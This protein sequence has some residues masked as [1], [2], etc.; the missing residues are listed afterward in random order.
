MESFLC[1]GRSYAY[2]FKF[3]RDGFIYHV[4]GDDI[5]HERETARLEFSQIDTCEMEFLS[6]SEK[7]IF[8]KRKRYYGFVSCSIWQL[9]KSGRTNTCVLIPVSLLTE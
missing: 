6:I 9:T 7:D 5:C 3:K 4:T 2:N 8:Q 1:F